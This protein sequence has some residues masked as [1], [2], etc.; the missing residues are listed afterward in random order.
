[1]SRGPSHE[2]DEGR[3]RGVL[4]HAKTD[5]LL[6]LLYARGQTGLNLEVEPKWLTCVDVEDYA[7][8]GLMMSEQTWLTGVVIF[9]KVKD[10]QVTPVIEVME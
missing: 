2:A 8:L 5:C 6:Y 4:H 7:V 1:M 3:F 9:T 10:L